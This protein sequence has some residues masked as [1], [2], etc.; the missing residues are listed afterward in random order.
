MKKRLIAASLMLAMFTGSA[1][2]VSS[3]TKTINVEYG[4]SLSING[5]TPTLTDVNGKTVQPFVYDGTTY[6]PIRAVS[7]NLGHRIEYFSSS[8]TAMLYG[9]TVVDRQKTF[10][11]SNVS[12]GTHELMLEMMAY[13][14]DDAEDTLVQGIMDKY[15]AITNYADSLK[16]EEVDSTSSA[17]GL[18][19]LYI[20]QLTAMQKAVT[21]FYNYKTSKSN[22]ELAAFYTAAK[23]DLIAFSAVQKACSETSNIPW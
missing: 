14:S 11:I 10:D 15:D 19:E 23:E 1:Y 5:Q 3:Y 7:D 6:V 22:A 2:A 18:K 21:A 12:H 9:I 20:P 16:L 4:V 8:D 13:L 17:D